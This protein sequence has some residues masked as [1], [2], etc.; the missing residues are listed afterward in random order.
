MFNL[1]LQRKYTFMK[2]VQSNESEVH[3][4]ICNATIN[5]A[6]DGKTGIER[7]LKTVKH[8]KALELKSKS[9]SVAQFLDRPINHKNSACEGLWAYH[10]VKSNHSF[11]S[12]DCASQIFRKC[13]DLKDFQSAR[14]KTEAIITGVIAP[15]AQDEVTKELASVNYVTLATDASNRKALKMMPVLARYFIPTVGVRIKVLELS[16]EKGETAVIIS[17]LVKNTAEKY[18]IESKIVGFSGDNCA[19][20]FGSVLRGGENNAY[21][22]LK[23]WRPKIVG[24]GCG[25]H[26]THNTLKAACESLPVDVEWLVVKIY[27]YFHIYTVRVEEL[28]KMCDEIEGLNY[29]QLLGYAKTRFLALG[30]AIGRI[31]EMFEPLKLFF[32]KVDGQTLIKSFFRN[33]HGKFWLIFARDQVSFVWKNMYIHLDM[34]KF[35]CSCQ[36]FLFRQNISNKRC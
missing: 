9:P 36:F 32:L 20:N 6:H 1:D 29:Q 33:P 8:T 35:I 34:S 23:Q 31:L 3:C 2:K 18:K 12:A 15:F 28:K 30:P 7:H 4:T 26:I 10:M 16:S 13:F 11:R 21:Y 25:A 22:L 5:I 19:A 17:N 24:I 27:S 14:T